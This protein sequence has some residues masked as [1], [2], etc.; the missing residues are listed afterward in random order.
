MHIQTIKIGKKGRFLRMNLNKVRV[1][2]QLRP[3]AIEDAVSSFIEDSRVK[4]IDKDGM[5]NQ[6]IESI[7]QATIFATNDASHFWLVH[8]GSD[9]MG[10]A[11]AHIGKDIDNKLTYTVSQAWVH[12][13]FRRKKIVRCWWEQIRTEAKRCLCKHIMFPAS[14]SVRAYLRYHKNTYQQYAVLLKE[15]I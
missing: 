6:T 10:Y 1:L 9:V 4:G 3:H 8:D 11:L 14:R 15:D 5:F 2:P 12:P 7:A 13:L